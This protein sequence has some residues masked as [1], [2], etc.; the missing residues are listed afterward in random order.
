MCAAEWKLAGDEYGV[1]VAT[2][3]KDLMSKLVLCESMVRSLRVHE[4]F[5]T[6][7]IHSRTTSYDL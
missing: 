1:L 4:S 6:T 3:R 5:L 2:G 7:Q